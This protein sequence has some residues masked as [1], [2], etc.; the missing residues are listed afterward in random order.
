MEKEGE[1]VKR[2]EFLKRQGDLFDPTISDSIAG[3]EN[4]RRRQRRASKRGEGIARAHALAELGI[5][6][7]ELLS[8][9]QA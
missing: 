8:S 7:A 9:G 2:A 3:K 6:E 1:I 5:L 4:A